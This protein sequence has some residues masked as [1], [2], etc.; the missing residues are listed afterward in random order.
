MGLFVGTSQAF[1]SQGGGS[2]GCPFRGIQNHFSS[3]FET[4]ERGHPRSGHKL[5]SH[6]LFARPLGLSP[7]KRL[8][9]SASTEMEVLDRDFPLRQYM[10]LRTPSLSPS[11]KKG[12]RKKKSAVVSPLSLEG[13]LRMKKIAS[14]QNLREIIV[15]GV[16]HRHAPVEIREQLAIPEEEWNS[17]SGALCESEAIEE[18]FVLSTCNRFEVYVAGKNEYEAMTDALKYLHDRTNGTVSKDVLRENIFVMTGDDALSHL[19][20]VA[21]GLDSMVLGEAQIQSQVRKAFTKGC[22]EEGGKAGQVLRQALESALC[23][24]KRVRSET[25]ICKGAMSVSSAAVEFTV[26][27]M[28]ESAEEQQKLFQAK[29][30]PACSSQTG[31]NEETMLPSKAITNS[32]IVIVGAGKMSRL[33]LI[34]LN[35][36]KV[37]KVTVVNRSRNSVE[38]LQ[39]ELK[40]MSITY[41]PIE[42][43]WEAIEG[44]DVVYTCTS[45]TSPLINAEE[46]QQC[47]QQRTKQELMLDSV[48]ENSSAGDS[49]CPAMD[50]SNEQSKLRKASLQRK[51]PFTPRLPLRFVDMSVPR[52]VHPS[53]GQVDG[54]ECCN[55]DDLKEVVKMNTAK[56]SGEIKGAE[57]I[58]NQEISNFHQW[59]ESLG[60]LPTIDRLQEKAEQMRLLELEKSM[61]DLAKLSPDDL[62]TVDRLSRGIVGKLINGPMEHLRNQNKVDDAVTAITQ[63]KQ[64]F[65]SVLTI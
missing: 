17:A 20:R 13:A 40:D 58:I 28:K 19:M 62:R 4:T 3:Y 33:L 34:H 11:T 43:M 63:L 22:Q 10:S 25:S 21:A 55:V 51:V 61:K 45:S 42:N 47:M 2:G 36:K 44:A 59:Q 53:C 52:N 50:K 24:G 6:G 32:N 60:A 12:R 65:H 15:V 14:D 46:L 8:L 39:D 16:S 5:D 64:A 30:K 18:A 27:R 49:N 38:K 48:V 31:C 26:A 56:R 41:T 57:S 9:G 37:R 29:H 7:Q 23:V 35:S 54:V 1:A